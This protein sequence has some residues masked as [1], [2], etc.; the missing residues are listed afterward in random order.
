M[1][2]MPSQLD[3]GFPE[4][5]GKTG[6]DGVSVGG[7]GVSVSVAVG[8]GVLVKVGKLVWVGGGVTVG[9]GVKALQDA[10]A[11]VRTESIIPLLMVFI[12]FLTIFVLEKAVGFV[13]PGRHGL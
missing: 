1:T 4:G 6:I 12:N 9:F 2:G 5:I 13:T 10:N 8:S 3:N 7:T 11:M